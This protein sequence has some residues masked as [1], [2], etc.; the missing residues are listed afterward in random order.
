[1]IAIVFA[2]STT[3]SSATT[4]CVVARHDLWIS[5]YDSISFV[6][7]FTVNVNSMLKCNLSAN[8]SVALRSLKGRSDSIKGSI[9]DYLLF[10]N[11]LVLD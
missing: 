7:F 8:P 3:A 4:S 1:M 5:F 10:V 6:R 9:I 2:V 11:Y